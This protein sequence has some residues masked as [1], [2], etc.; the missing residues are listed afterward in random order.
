MAQ[1]SKLA[2]V[3]NLATGCNPNALV[4]CLSGIPYHSKSLYIMVKNT[5]RKRLTAFMMTAKRNNHASPDI[6]AAWRG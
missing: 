5:W 3:A 6:L 1:V 4:F 2:E